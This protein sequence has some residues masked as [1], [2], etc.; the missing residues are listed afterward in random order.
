M[1]VGYRNLY[2]IC[3]FRCQVSVFRFQ[4]KSWV[5]ESIS[6]TLKPSC[7]EALRPD[8]PGPN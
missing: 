2:G 6:W 7:L 4:E 3:V 1:T 8:A 5:F